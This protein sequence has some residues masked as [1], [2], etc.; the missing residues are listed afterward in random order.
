MTLRTFAS[1][2]SVA[3]CAALISS[4]SRLVMDTM[5]SVSIAWPRG[6]YARSVVV[7]ERAARASSSS[8]IAPTE[9]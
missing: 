5:Y 6:M 3:A 8:S 9:M 7:T 2:T 1:A 4:G